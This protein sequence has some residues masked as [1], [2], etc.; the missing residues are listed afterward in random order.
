MLLY[1]ALSF[2][3]IKM[4][5]YALRLSHNIYI[6]SGEILYYNFFSMC[7]LKIYWYASHEMFLLYK[8]DLTGFVYEKKNSLVIGL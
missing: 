7:W 1:C 8:L 2:T 3:L 6:V 4:L 5:Y